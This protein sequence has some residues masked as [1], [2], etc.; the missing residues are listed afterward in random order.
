MKRCNSNG[1]GK[2]K[3]AN[4]K[5][6]KLDANIG[7]T[8]RMKSQFREPWLE[9]VQGEQVPKIINS[10]D[11]FIRVEAGPG[12][13]KTYGLARRVKRILHPQ[14]LGAPGREVLVV[15]FNRVIAKQLRQDIEECLG[16]APSREMPIIQTVHALCL[17]LLDREL[18]ILLPHEREAMIYDVIYACPQICQEFNTEQGESFTRKWTRHFGTMKRNTNST[19]ICGKL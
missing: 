7:G 12:T 6:N 19:T 10:D 14:G 3:L 18:R 13:G 2:G 17:Q 4:A 9:D 15:A 11:E 5:E 1:T 16:A 8:T